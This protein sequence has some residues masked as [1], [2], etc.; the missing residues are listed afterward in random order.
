MPFIPVICTSCGASLQVDSSKRAAICPYCD[1]AYVV[2][3]AKKEYTTKVEKLYANVVNLNDDRAANARLEAG[4]AFLKLKQ[5]A[6]ADAAFRDAC[7]LTP[8]NYLGWWG[9]IR[10]LSEDF[11]L[12]L[13]DIGDP[14]IKTIRFREEALAKL[15]DLFNSADMFVPAGEKGSIAQTFRPYADAV[16]VTLLKAKAW[17]SRC[18][19]KLRQEISQAAGQK[20]EADRNAELHDDRKSTNHVYR[21]THRGLFT[22]LMLLFIVCIVWFLLSLRTTPSFIPAAIIVI[23]FLILIICAIVDANSKKYNRNNSSLQDQY[24]HESWELDRSIHEHEEALKILNDERTP[25][26]TGA[27][28]QAE[29]LLQAVI[30]SVRQA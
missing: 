10:A 7:D 30:T 14:M 8:Q 15:E 28:H 20:A 25:G 24:R 4:E 29:R 27:D 12:Y 2:E 26:Q 21:L 11:S 18:V 19:Q 22:F 6:N 9:R 5:W 1:Q 13:D 3:D 17:N 16:N 23:E